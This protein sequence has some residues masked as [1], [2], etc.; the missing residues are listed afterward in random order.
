MSLHDCNLTWCIVP[1]LDWANSRSC[2]LVLEAPAPTPTPTSTPTPNLTLSGRSSARSD[3]QIKTGES[4]TRRAHEH[5]QGANEQENRRIL[6]SKALHWTSATYV[7]RS[8]L[9]SLSAPLI[10]PDDP[11]IYRHPAGLRPVYVYP[12]C[13]PSSIV[14]NA[15]SLSNHKYVSL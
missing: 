7:R 10:K 1:M 11:P 8:G 3:T 12:V 5:P 4:D 14:T 2:T 6:L 13:L 9:N 15:I